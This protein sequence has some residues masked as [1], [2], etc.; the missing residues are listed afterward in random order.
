[1]SGMVARPLMPPTAGELQRMGELSQE[2]AQAQRQTGRDHPDADRQRQHDAAGRAAHHRAEAEHGALSAHAE[3]AA[4]AGLPVADHALA[5]G[6]ERG[7]SRRGPR[8]RARDPV[9]DHAALLGRSLPLRS[10]AVLAGCRRRRASASASKRSALGAP[11]A[12]SLSRRAWRE[13]ASRRDSRGP[14][15]RANTWRPF[16]DQLRAVGSP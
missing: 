5:L 2:T 15:T 7:G 3:Y 11:C 4:N 12:R 16:R 1:V 14:R 13:T 8:P 10:L 6:C 9:A